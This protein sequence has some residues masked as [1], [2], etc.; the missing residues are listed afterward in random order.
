[1]PAWQ[2]AETAASG[3]HFSGGVTVSRAQIATVCRQVFCSNAYLV[4]RPQPMTFKKPNG[5]NGLWLSW[6]DA[7]HLLDV[8]PR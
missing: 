8:A 7:E 6:D 1:M 4:G 3:R 2:T 5:F